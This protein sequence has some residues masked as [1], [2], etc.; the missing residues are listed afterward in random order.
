M[1]SSLNLTLLRK[2]G[3]QFT[4]HQILRLTAR[5][6][7]Q[8]ERKSG[9]DSLCAFLQ[10]IGMEVD[11]N[12]RLT[13]GIFDANTGQFV[14]T[15]VKH[16]LRSFLT[17]ALIKGHFMGNKGYKIPGLPSYSKKP[18]VGDKSIFSGRS[19]PPGLRWNVY[20]RDNFK[21]CACGHGREE[22]VKLHVDH[23]IPVSQG[24]LTEMGNLQVLCATCNLGK[25]NRSVRKIGERKSDQGNNSPERLS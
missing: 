22:G 4:V 2:N 14:D 23:I 19:I 17:A 1:L 18:D 8:D 10:S 5:K 12:R 21:C 6:M 7:T 11:E 13:L 25:G 15:S 3:A 20:E 16:F 24:G 9:A